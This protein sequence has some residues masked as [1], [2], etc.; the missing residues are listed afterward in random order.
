MRT[1]RK[2]FSTSSYKLTHLSKI[3]AASY[4]LATLTILLLIT[5]AMIILAQ[6][7]ALNA[8]TASYFSKAEQVAFHMHK[9][10]DLTQSSKHTPCSKADLDRLE[11]IQQ[12][13]FFIGVL[14]RTSENKI[15]CSTDYAVVD[16]PVTLPPIHAHTPDGKGYHNTQTYIVQSDDNPPM[17]TYQDAF[18]IPSNAYLK[19]TTPFYSTVKGSTA[20]TY[21]NGNKRYIHSY[22]GHA[23][24]KEFDAL[25]A[26]KNSWLD[27]LPFPNSLRSTTRCND[28]YHVCTTGID[29]KVGLFS[30]SKKNVLIF[31]PILVLASMA[32]GIMIEHL[33]VGPRAFIRKLKKQIQHD[34]IY[35][36]YQPQIKLST[37][38]I[39][40]V[41]MLARW[42][43][44]IIGNV[45]PDLFIGVAEESNLIDT[46]TEKLVARVFRDLHETLYKNPAFTVSINISTDL[47]TSDKFV[48]FLNHSMSLYSFNRN[49]IILEV[50][51]RK[52]SDHDEMA[53]FSKKLQAQGY[54]VSIDDFGTGVS[55][56]SWLSTLEPNEIKVDKTFTQA[57]GTETVNSITLG[58]IFSMLEHLSVK[59]VF[60][61]I[62]TEAQRDYI[63]QKI[64]NAYGQGW[65]FSKALSINDL[66]KTLSFDSQSSQ[67]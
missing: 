41:E 61:G 60:E 65:L 24:P 1:T 62:E 38:E 47:L 23:L 49:Q 3:S 15:I 26:H 45:P 37:N 31:L 9:A 30:L 20:I 10:L 6:S 46:L 34:N 55:N 29:K 8:F 50:T 14:G 53:L 18:A 54:L 58:G 59:V 11:E 16:N 7:E 12:I 48:R 13:Y 44:P 21:Y 2:L 42:H 56:L 57:I 22:V 36:V 40:G 27:W 35:P 66:L 32:L 63:Q 33:R 17:M 39:I 4:A 5:H 64:S 52:A 51:E 19:I 67:H 28:L 43:D 25:I